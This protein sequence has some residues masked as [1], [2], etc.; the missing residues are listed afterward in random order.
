MNL[1]KY[2]FKRLIGLVPI[3]IIISFIS[4]SLMKLAPSDPA[5]VL[6]NSQGTVIT[7]ELLETT[8]VEMGLDKPFF[9]QY[10]NKKVYLRERI[11]R[12]ICNV[13]RR[14]SPGP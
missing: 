5:E 10:I 6:L 9:I 2:I 7:A 4:F 1:L 3:L 13:P 11:G 12:G 8:R 14:I